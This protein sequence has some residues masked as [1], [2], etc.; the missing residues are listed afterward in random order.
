L[1]EQKGTSDS[2]EN[3]NRI[4]RLLRLFFKDR[5]CFTLVRPV[6]DEKMLQQLAEIDPKLLREEF[7]D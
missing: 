5:D 3:K 2:I 7:V 4:R 6:E 1:K